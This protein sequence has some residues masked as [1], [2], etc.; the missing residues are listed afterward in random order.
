MKEIF[1]PKKIGKY[2]YRKWWDGK[3]WWYETYVVEKITPRTVVVSDV[4]FGTGQ[5][6][7]G[8]FRLSRQGLER[9]GYDVNPRRSA[10][11][12]LEMP[13]E[14]RRKTIGF[15]MQTKPR[16][17]LG[18]PDVFSREQLMDAYR[19]AARETHP[20]S[21]GSHEQFLRIQAAYE[22]LEK[23]FEN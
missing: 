13:E 21:G 14:Y 17:V 23:L 3:D 11:F 22:T 12:Y 6:N 15:L 2:I 4:F 5:P 1:Q 10:V 20:D 9:R 8:R 16:E 19:K 18:L 7:E